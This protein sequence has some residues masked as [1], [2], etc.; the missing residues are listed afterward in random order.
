M[1]MSLPV[2]RTSWITVMVLGLL[3][4]SFVTAHPIRESDHQGEA[5][6]VVQRRDPVGLLRVSS[7]IPLPPSDTNSIQRL[8]PS[9][10]DYLSDIFGMLGISKP[11]SST[12]TPTPTPTPTQTPS[13]YSAPGIYA[14]Q[15]TPTNAKATPTSENHSVSFT[16]TIKHDANDKPIE[17]VQI[18]S[19]WKG[20][21][22][23]IKA[24][25][26]PV[27]LQMAYKE[28]ANRFNDAIDSSD[29]VGLWR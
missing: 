28:I 7:K 8:I 25:D 11:S 20:D 6:S 26:V 3:S 16:G 10:E 29:E 12:P 14:E 18:G 2:P 13:Y 15:G 1:N 19:G 5:P 23:R 9:S 4:V 24:E 22:K 21:G 27:I 17:N